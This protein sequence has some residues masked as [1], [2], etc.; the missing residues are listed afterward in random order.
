ME[1]VK[2]EKYLSWEE[3]LANV[4]EFSYNQ[5]RWGRLLRSIKEDKDFATELKEQIE[6]NKYIDF[7]DFCMREG[8]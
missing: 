2:E 7:C 4:K 1:N 3:F 5:G 6:T 8:W